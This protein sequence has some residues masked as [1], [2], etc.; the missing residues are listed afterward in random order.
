LRLRPLAQHDGM[1][2]DGRGQI[3]GVFFLRRQRQ[4]NNLGVVFG[5]LR[6]IGR[7][8]GSMRDLADSDHALS[9][10]LLFGARQRAQHIDH[11]GD[12]LIV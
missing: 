1:M 6:Q 4:A 11:H 12:V 10:S 7:L 5:L 2:I 9:P 3:N 8:V